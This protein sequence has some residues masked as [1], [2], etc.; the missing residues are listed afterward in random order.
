M[1]TTIFMVTGLVLSLLATVTLSAQEVW[2]ARKN[3][4]VDS[5]RSK[6]EGRLISPKAALTTVDI[7][8]AVGTYQAGDAAEAAANVV[9]SLDAE[10]KGLVWIE[11]L[12]QGRIKAMLRQ[13][14]AVYKIPAQKTDGGREV[15]EGV[16]IYDPQNNR[17]D[18]C[19]G[20]TFS[21]ENPGAAFAAAEETET[22]VV[23]TKSGKKTKTVAK[24]KP[25]YFTAS[26]LI[27]TTAAAAEAD[28]EKD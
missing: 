24:A 16:L 7:F 17:L 14:P 13:S 1:K 8:P 2:D 6:Y 3:P 20:C 15:K 28:Q 5:I 21:S 11:G 22:I 18:I 19:I 12:P 23:K 27:E 26:K 10:N 4:T 9:I 25:W